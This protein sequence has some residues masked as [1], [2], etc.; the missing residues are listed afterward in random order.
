M[1]Y[2][3]S[4]NILTDEMIGMVNISFENIILKNYFANGNKIIILND[5]VYYGICYLDFDELLSKNEKELKM[6]LYSYTKNYYFLTRYNFNFDYLQIK[7]WRNKCNDFTEHEMEE[8]DHSN[9]MSLEIYFFV[10]NNERSKAMIAFNI[11]GKELYE[12]VYVY[13]QKTNDLWTILYY[14]NNNTVYKIVQTPF[15]QFFSAPNFG[16]KQNVEVLI[17]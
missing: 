1:Q 15:V 17:W 9:L 13:L 11:I 12:T 16:Y 5:N 3:Y 8:F 14:K 6:F 4:D 7:E 2:I 10:L